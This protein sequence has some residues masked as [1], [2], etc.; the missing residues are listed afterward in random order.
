MPGKKDLLLRLGGGG[1]GRQRR[2]SDKTRNK[3]IQ[4][5]I[6]K[7]IQEN[8]DTEKKALI[9]LGDMNGHTGLLEQ[10][11]DNW[12]IYHAINNRSKF[13]TPK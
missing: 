12:E 13:N 6:L 10:N 9:L 11:L 7:K 5:E 8:Q 1:G 4:N 3:T 2:Q